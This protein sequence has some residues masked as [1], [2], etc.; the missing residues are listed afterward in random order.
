MLKYVESTLNWLLIK[1]NKV[2]TKFLESPLQKEWHFL[3]HGYVIPNPNKLARIKQ[4]ENNTRQAYRFFYQMSR[5][6]LLFIEDLISFISGQVLPITKLNRDLDPTDN[7]MQLKKSKEIYYFIIKEQHSKFSHHFILRLHS[8]LKKNGFI[9]CTLPDLKK[10]FIKYTDERP[11]SS[12]KPIIWTGKYYNSLAYLIRRLSG[13][14]L[15]RT[16]APSNYE[17]AI[18][19]FHNNT[20]GSL[21]TPSKNRYDYNLSRKVKEIIDNIV[22]ESWQNL[23]DNTIK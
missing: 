14:F 7:N 8:E 11:D 4:D 20:E 17:I 6:Q 15:I 1:F 13:T 19:L 5:I 10:L 2:R 12:P 18:N 3:S 23:D 21:F 22:K 16:K 9:N